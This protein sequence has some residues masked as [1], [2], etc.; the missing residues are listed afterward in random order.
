MRY[1]YCFLSIALLFFSCSRAPEDA[2]VAVGVSLKNKTTADIYLETNFPISSSSKGDSF[3]EIITALHGRQFFGWESM[4]RIRSYDDFLAQLLNSYPDAR[5]WIYS[6][7][8]DSSKGELLLSCPMNELPATIWGDDYG[9]FHSPN[10]Y[11]RELWF[12]V[13]WYGDVLL[14]KP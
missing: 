4:R 13:S 6:V 5:I 7:N 1:L 10:E 2:F 12:G 3:G 11:P 14:G 8:E 9:P